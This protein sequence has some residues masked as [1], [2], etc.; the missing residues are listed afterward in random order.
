MSDLHNR[1]MF[2]QAAIAAG[3]TWAAADL[4]HVEEALLWAAQHMVADAKDVRLSALSSD[5]AEAIT[6]M[7]S[8]ILPSVDGRPGAREAGVIY[9]IDRSLSTFNAAKKPLYLDGIKDLN[10]R[11]AASGKGSVNFAALAEAQQDEILLTIEHTRFF[12]AVRVDTLTGTFALPSWGGNREF[13][14]WHLLGMTHAA[15]YE[16]PF[17]YYDD[18]ANGGPNGPSSAAPTNAPPSSPGKGS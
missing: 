5:Q 13:A 7:A 4:F 3:A 6:A 1:R 12:R 17:G 11:A 15:R 8:R 9:F 14:G 18:A 16:P 10:S 2:L